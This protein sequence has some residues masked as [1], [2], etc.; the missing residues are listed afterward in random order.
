MLG[1][2]K[3][4]ILFCHEDMRPDLP[5]LPHQAVSPRMP[6]VPLRDERKPCIT[7][8]REQTNSLWSSFDDRY[9][10]LSA[11]SCGDR[12]DEG[13][14]DA[15]MAQGAGI[16]IENAEPFHGRV[17][18]MRAKNVPMASTM[19]EASSSFIKEKRGR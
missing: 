1:V 3:E 10:D 9:I 16:V 18:R 2:A 17:F 15:R 11:G 7:V 12:L 19:N 13:V 8:D 5:Y 4:G 14:N 6:A